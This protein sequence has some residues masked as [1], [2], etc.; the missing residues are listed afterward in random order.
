MLQVGI[1]NQT[2]RLVDLKMACD[3]AC[4]ALDACFLFEGTC[5][6]HSQ[7]L[8]FDTSVSWRIFYRFEWRLM[9]AVDIQDNVALT[10]VIDNFRR[11]LGCVYLQ[12]DLLKTMIKGL[13][14]KIEGRHVIERSTLA[15]SLKD[16][17]RAA[18]VEETLEV[19]QIYSL[20]ICNAVRDVRSR[21]SQQLLDMVRSDIDEHFA[22]ENFGLNEAAS[23]VGISPNYLSSM[24]KKEYGKGIHE[25]IT[26]HRIEKARHMLIHTEKSM[27]DIGAEVGYPNP[28]HF[29][30]NF[31]KHVGMAP[32]EYRKKNRK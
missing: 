29:S 26:T 9:R 19:L 1:S 13:L 15:E 28:Y 18:S 27:G 12:S 20:D 11:E 24:F 22:D 16:I 3:D 6:I 4:Q 14:F 8:S 2:D 5:V 17:D 23:H 31:K 32:T 30:S 10:Q 7:D 25:Y 21:Y